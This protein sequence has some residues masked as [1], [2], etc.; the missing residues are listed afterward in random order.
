MRIK[1]MMISMAMVAS[2]T[3]VAHAEPKLT[4]KAAAAVKQAREAKPITR[5]PV[6]GLKAAKD[7]GAKTVRKPTRAEDAA[8]GTTPVT[9]TTVTVNPNGSVT[10]FLGDEHL[11]DL[12]VVK[13]A[14]GSLATTCTTRG[15]DHTVEAKAK[16]ATRV[17]KSET[18]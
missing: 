13:Q 16:R 17:Q 1:T 11:S 9:P 8:L 14:D 15:H 12:V 10:A 3:L 7:P 18:R 4:P 2:A 6:A 5:V